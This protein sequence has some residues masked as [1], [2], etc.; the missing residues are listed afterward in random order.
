[1]FILQRIVLFF[2]ERIPN[3]VRWLFRQLR[4]ALRFLLRV[5]VRLVR[6]TVVA[7]AWLAVVFGPLTLHPGMIALAWMFLAL[8]GSSLGL[9][10]YERIRLGLIHISSRIHR[11]FGF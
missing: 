7:T 8:A 5:A 3:V 9:R 6:L 4:A 10:R 11:N 2:V 1:M